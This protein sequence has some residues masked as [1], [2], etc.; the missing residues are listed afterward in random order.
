MIR[1]YT[2]SD[3]V[4]LLSYPAETFM[5]RLF[6]QADD[7]G[8]FYADPTLLKAKLYPKR[9]DKI[10]TSEIIKWRDECRKA[11]I[12]VMY[13]YD[14]KPYLQIV[15]FRQRLDRA[16]AKF[17]MPPA[18]VYPLPVD[19]DFPTPSKPAKAPAEKKVFTPPTLKEVEDYFVENGYLLTAAAKAYK[20]YDTADW[21]YS[22]DR[23]IK[24]WKQK[25]QGV[26]FKPENLAPVK[27]KTTTIDPDNQW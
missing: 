4:D 13:E 20:Y 3:K 24:N 21:H 17:P 12:I 14:G 16:R 6:T 15:D 5:N 7:H 9:I 25:M 19:D 22:N 27:H 2:N 8:L 10:K 1:D 18:D 11:G 26:W 23:K